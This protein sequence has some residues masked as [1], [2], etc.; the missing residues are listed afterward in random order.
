[1]GVVYEYRCQKCGD[2]LEL[3]K[4]PA[5]PFYN[6][7]FCDGAQCDGNYARWYSFGVGRVAGAGGSPAK[8]S[9]RRGE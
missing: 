8:Q 9:R 2:V 7:H 5:D 4:R 6:T 3:D 1:M